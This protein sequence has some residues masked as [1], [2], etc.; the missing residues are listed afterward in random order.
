MH[1]VFAAS[2][3]I[4]YSKTGGLAD[5]MGALP[6]ALAHAGHDVSVFV[7]KY[8]DT[9]LDSPETIIHSLTIP[10]DDQYRFCSIL[11]GGKIQGVR[12]Y[13]V[14]YPL[15]FDRPGIYGSAVGDYPDNAERFAMLSRAVLEASKILGVPDLF[16]CHDWQT[17]LIPVLLKSQYAEDPALR[18]AASVLTIHNVGYQGV[19]APETLPLLTLPWDLFTMSKMEFFG[20]VNFLKGGVAYADF[21]T[22]VSRK[23][24]RE[25]QTAEYGFGLE[26]A[27]RDRAASLVGILNGVDYDLWDPAKDKFVAANYTPKD[28]EGKTACKQDLLKEFA[29]AP[30]GKRTPLIGIVSRF[31]GQKGFDLIAQII[32]RLAQEDVCMVVLGSGEKRY[33]EMF[34]RIQKLFPAKFGLKIGYDNAMAHKIEAGSDMFLM[35]SRYEPC[36]L[37]QIYSLKYG[38]VPVVRATG[39]LDDTIEP[40]DSRTRKGTGFKFADYNAE[41]FLLVIKHALDAYREPDTWQTLMRNGMKKEFSWTVSAREYVKVYER[42]RQAREL[43]VS[44]A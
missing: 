42:A 10:F 14:D 16:H 8:R 29:L 39:G 37:N 5:V 18:D 44:P 33:E 15:F 19:F 6:Q 25:I 11:D 36:G 30:A 31:A 1:I 24:A 26:G 32:D 28:L 41:S 2:E 22:T 3:C 34:Q 7:P 35:P 23:Y 27:L 21:V 40:F 12:H 20:S 38:T 17:A 43:P 9:R 13:F 4:P